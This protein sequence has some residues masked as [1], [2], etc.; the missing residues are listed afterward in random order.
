MVSSTFLGGTVEIF[1]KTM[2]LSTFL[3]GL[4]SLRTHIPYHCLL[5]VPAT[6]AN[7]PGLG[8]QKTRAPLSPGRSSFLKFPAKADLIPRS[9]QLEVPH[10]GYIYSEIPVIYASPNPNL[11][12]GVS[13]SSQKGG[14]FPGPRFFDLFSDGGILV[15]KMLESVVLDCSLP[16]KLANFGIFEECSSVFP[17]R[18]PVQHC[19]FYALQS[20]HLLFVLPK[21]PSICDFWGCLG[22]LF[23]LALID[24]YQFDWIP[25]TLPFW[26]QIRD[27]DLP[28]NWG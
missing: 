13:R 16:V 19:P 2:V 27:F 14:P 10:I 21:T 8:T 7:I 5:L 25:K 23:L 3:G 4:S 22:N 12:E 28:L 26:N 20:I 11:P 24:I 17:G 15:R 6:G 9:G 18:I 1:A